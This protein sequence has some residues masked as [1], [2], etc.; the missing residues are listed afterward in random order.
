MKILELTNYS[1]GICGVWQRVLQESIELKKKGHEVKIFTSNKTKGSD[2]IASCSDKISEIPIHR[3]PS[4]KLGGE[5]FMHWKFEKEFN[6]FN[7]DIVI[8]H[9][10]RHPHTTKALK[11]SKGKNKKVILITHAP[12]GPG[13]R[14]GNFSK[15]L[16]KLY[17]I[18]IGRPSLK[19]FSKVVA[20]SNWEKPYLKKLGLKGEILVLGN[21]IPEE[22]FKLKKSKEQNKIVFLG[23]IAPIKDLETLI[24]AFSKI[25]NK[26]INLELVGPAEEDY[27]Q[28]LKS[29]IKKLNLEKRIIFS[30]AVYETEEKIKKLDSAKMFILPSKREGMPQALIEAMA[31]SKIVI[32]SNNKGC[33][34]IINSGKN[35]FLFPIGHS[36]KLV[37]LIN[38][39]LTL[40]K[41]EK[42]KLEKQAKKSVE[43]FSW[44]FI[45]PKLESL[46]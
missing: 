9:S 16:V 14:R 15:A 30:G 38:K 43:K 24:F 6:E 23:R 21:G 20:I 25:D 17:D 35:G 11:Y 32:A 31:R 40:K 39:V 7:P 2:K 22:F 13:N 46:F 27:L 44:S 42:S 36:K 28:K 10:Y 29:L 3:F 41:S 5:S 4:Q 26:K 37:S 8:V 19:R 18:F 45:I 34:D 12:F 1:A 33:E